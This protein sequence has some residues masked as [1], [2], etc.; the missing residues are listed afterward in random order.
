MIPTEILT[1]SEEEAVNSSVASNKATK[2]ESAAASN[3]TNQCNCTEEPKD[4]RA[5]E[6]IV[7]SLKRLFAV[8]IALSFQSAAN[9]VYETFSLI[10]RTRTS[11]RNKSLAFSAIGVELLCFF[12]FIATLFVYYYQSDRYFDKLFVGAPPKKIRWFRL[13]KEFMFNTLTMIPFIF[14]ARSIIPTEKSQTAVFSFGWF[15]AG[16]NLLLVWSC[17]I[18][19]ADFLIKTYREFYPNGVTSTEEDRNA[20]AAAFFWLKLDNAFCLV[21]LL[22]VWILK[23]FGMQC[24]HSRLVTTGIFSLLFIARSALDIHYSWPLSF[25]GSLP[26]PGKILASYTAMEENLRRNRLRY[27]MLTVITAT[28]FSLFVYYNYRD[29]DSCGVNVLL[30]DSSAPS[31]SAADAGI[32][33]DG[34][35]VIDAG[36]SIEPAK[37]SNGNLSQGKTPPPVPMVPAADAVNAGVQQPVAL[38]SGRRETTIVSPQVRPHTS[39]SASP[40]IPSRR[41]PKVHKK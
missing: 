24:A 32:A 29:F 4:K 15:F 34:G 31:N 20:D 8:I 7:D 17:I 40:V 23:C 9:G 38:P 21:V 18:L 22:F 3:K 13:S 19:A 1:G 14:I 41:L 28:V 2:H 36:H 5:I 6:R 26:Q 25:P 39:R 37:L 30:S 27:I 35:H 12:A 10:F 11:Y 16:C 33:T